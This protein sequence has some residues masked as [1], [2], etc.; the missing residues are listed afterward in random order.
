MLFSSESLPVY[1]IATASAIAVASVVIFARYK[2][3]SR[4]TRKQS[5]VIS[6]IVIYPIKG[7]KGVERY[8]AHVSKNG[9]VHDREYAVVILDKEKPGHCVALSQSKHPRLSLV[10]P[11]NIYDDSITISAHGNG[12]IVHQPVMKGKEYW[13]DFYGDQIQAVDQ[14]DTASRWFSDFLGEEVRFVRITQ[15]K[16]RKTSAGSLKPATIF[17]KTPVLVVSSESLDSLSKSVGETLHHN[18]FRPNLVLSGL[19]PFEEDTL[20]GFC[21]GPLSLTGTELCDRCSIPGVDQSTGQLNTG[22]LGQLRRARQGPAIKSR[23]P[24]KEDQYYVGLYTEP[25]VSKNAST[26]IYVGQSVERLY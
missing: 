9:L 24:V 6:H 19:S 25:S 20:A 5:P 11:T 26:R 14:G 21:V 10:S 1:A 22:L 3:K 18:R 2:I 15:D 8:S 13:M 12:T 16:K 4:N 23:Y 7:C 17:Y